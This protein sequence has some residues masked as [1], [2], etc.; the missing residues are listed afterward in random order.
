GGTAG[1]DNDIDLD[2]DQ[3]SREYGQAFRL[4]LGVSLFDHEVPPFDVAEVTQLLAERL[5]EGMTAGRKPADADLSV[6]LATSTS[7]PRGSAGCKTASEGTAIHLLN[8]LIR[9]CQQRRRNRKPQRLRGLEV[10]GQLEGRGLFDGKIQRPA[11][12]QD[13]VHEYGNTRNEVPDIGT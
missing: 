13:L 3:F 2:A 1:R 6:G 10:H 5:D 4:A 11:P 12:S 7:R 8:D 9:P